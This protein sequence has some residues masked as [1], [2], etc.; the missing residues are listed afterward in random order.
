MAARAL[1]PCLLWAPLLAVLAAGPRV[2]AQGQPAEAPS[3]GSALAPA[4]GT[5][6]LVPPTPAWRALRP[7]E[8]R[9]F[10]PRAIA[11]VA[12]SG[13]VRCALL[14]E[15]SRRGDL[16][17]ITRE[18][19]AAQG[20]D[21]P[22]QG[23]LEPTEILNRPAFHGLVSGK[24]D[25]QWWRYHVLVFREQSDLYWLLSRGIGEEVPAD[26]SKFLEAADGL[27]FRQGASPI[28]LAP[29]RVV[30]DA[31]DVGWR[32]REGVYRNAALGF[33]LAPRGPWRV[34][35]GPEFA[36]LGP[37]IL[38]GLVD[39]QL[40]ACVGV[41]VERLPG[42]E[43]EKHL[44]KIR[45]AQAQVGH[46]TGTRRVQI[47]AR[48]VELRVQTVASISGDVGDTE[49]RASAVFFEDE[50]C[51][52]LVVRYPAPA[53]KQVA[54]VLPQAFS[55]LRLM[56]EAE[57]AQLASE[58]MAEPDHFEVVGE[59]FALRRGT[60]S[61]FR[62]SFRWRSPA[63]FW[64]LDKSP[65]GRPEEPQAVLW[66][67]ER[68]L[69]VEGV[70]FVEEAGAEETTS[71]RHAVDLARRFG[72]GPRVRTSA[73]VELELGE[74]PALATWCDPGDGSER[75]H[76]LV[77]CVARGKAFELRLSGPVK[78]M[79]R[80]AS[81]L[82]Q[83]VRSLEISLAPLAPNSMTRGLYRDQRMGFELERPAP[84]WRFNE[85]RVDRFGPQ[86]SNAQGV[87]AGFEGEGHSG[88]FAAAIWSPEVPSE[89][90]G[91][92]ESLLPTA[93]LHLTALP[94]GRPDQDAPANFAGRRGRLLIWSEVS[95]RVELLLLVR[96]STLYAVCASSGPQDPAP[97]ERMAAFRLLD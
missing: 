47:G 36:V 2:E 55:G 8:L 31:Q 6:T 50:R 48:E 35:L 22:S 71:S 38:I 24:R 73:S 54:E 46:S 43:T 70:L 44:E 65:R 17:A 29:A 89:A 34:G 82:L 9:E 33:E 63:G 64:E 25:R 30:P 80:N 42:V 15:P 66:L 95:R 51:I 21:R 41:A 52:Q 40:G 85:R 69:A 78:A 19:L 1:V 84:Q 77:T 28:Q 14:A 58:M 23:L 83:S 37:E 61:D 26:G 53:D 93:F 68:A 90:A 60:Y 5:F 12:G 72:N 59:G 74:V 87:L 79:E 7:G 57:R 56:D 97:R 11:G 96:D 49:I 10:G 16:E 81:V 75:R 67:R 32:L 39:E 92:V 86:M 45:R 88:L 91:T 13:T 76:L 18:L 27:R 3:A 20:L 4:T 62:H 94:E